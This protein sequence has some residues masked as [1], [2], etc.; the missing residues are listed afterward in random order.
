MLS[1]RIG[2]SPITTRTRAVVAAVAFAFVVP[3]AGFVVHA[4]TPAGFSGSVFDP[5]GRVVANARVTLSNSQTQ[6]RHEVR[7]DAAG[8][9][10]FTDVAAGDY[11]ME[12]QLPGFMTVKS[13]VTI[14]GG[15]M[16]QDLHLALGSIR[17]TVVVRVPFD[18]QAGAAGGAQFPGPVRVIRPQ[19]QAAPCSDAGTTGGHIVPPRKLSDWKPGYPDNLRADKIVGEVTVEGVVA[20]DGVVRD[21][22]VVSAP[23]AD[24]GQAVV[25]AVSRWAFSATLLN[26]QPVDVKITVIARFEY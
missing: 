12:V 6:A 11:A 5:A 9:F 1:T 23:H 8:H 24:L 25:D 18:A 16:Q 3:L 22:H 13:T 19:A 21:L 17:E 15:G 4:Q 20:A 26:C 7:S 14:T 2:R 10:A